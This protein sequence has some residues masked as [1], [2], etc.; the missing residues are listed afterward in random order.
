MAKVKESEGAVNDLGYPKI[1][2]WACLQNKK[3]TPDGVDGIHVF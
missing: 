2:L 1:R 3:H